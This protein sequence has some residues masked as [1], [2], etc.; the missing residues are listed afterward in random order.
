ME[1]EKDK[2]G[3]AIA[4][5]VVSV[6]GFWIFGIILGIIAIILGALSIE[7]GLG[8][9]GLVIGIID[10]VGVIIIMGL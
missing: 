7:K 4:S 2:S 8:K 6:I 3:L 5:F 10:V 9:A 1:K